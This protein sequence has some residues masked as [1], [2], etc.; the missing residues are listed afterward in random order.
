MKLQRTRHLF[1]L[2]LTLTALLVE[3]ASGADGPTVS[4]GGAPPTLFIIGDSTVRNGTRGLMGWGDCL[5]AS[6]DTSEIKIANRA[7]GGRSSRTFY[8]EGLW[9]KVRASLQ[10]GDFVLMQFGHNDGGPLTGGRGRA[11]LKGN[12]EE[13]QEVIHA[14]TGRKEVVH[15]YGWYLRQYVA[16]AKS[17]GATAIVLSQV[18]RNMWTGGKV[19]RAANDYG[20]W[21]RAAARQGEALFIDLNEL[22]A[23]RY[24]EEGPAKVQAQYFTSADHTHTTAAGA[25]LNAA[26]VAQGL[27]TL[28]NCPLSRFVLQKPGAASPATP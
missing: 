10:P 3:L 25:R 1:A 28:T 16:D 6:L 22:V 9:E 19:N 17:K 27:R 20:Q 23:K 5:A 4:A 12:G 26:C 7:L 14:G 15:T 24:E 2:A 18:P 11:S 8:T 21:A 13:A